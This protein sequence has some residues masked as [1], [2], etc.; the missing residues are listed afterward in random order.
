VTIAEAEL[1]A[2]EGRESTERVQRTTPGCLP[3]PQGG[4]GK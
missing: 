4:C 1:M 2:N 3:G